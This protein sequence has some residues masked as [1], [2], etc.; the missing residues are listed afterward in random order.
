MSGRGRVPPVQSGHNRNDQPAPRDDP[1]TV[2]AL[3][4]RYLNLSGPNDR[5]PTW[6]TCGRILALSPLGLLLYLVVVKICDTLVIIAEKTSGGLAGLGL[7]V[8]ALG[9]ASGTFWG[10]LRKV[11]ALVDR[12]PGDGHPDNGHQDDDRPTND[13]SQNDD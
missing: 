2:L 6:S 5:R 7:A 11:R 10:L 1:K 3:F 8:A 12:L 9:A 4:S 13:Q